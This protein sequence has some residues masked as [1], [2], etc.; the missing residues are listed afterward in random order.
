MVPKKSNGTKKK[1]TNHATRNFVFA[2]Y[3]ISYLTPWFV[4]DWPPSNQQQKNQGRNY[5]LKT[6]LILFQNKIPLSLSSSLLSLCFT[7]NIKQNKKEEEEVNNNNKKSLIK[8]NFPISFLFSPLHPPPP[9]LS[10]HQH[11]HHSLFFLSLSLPPFFLFVNY[12]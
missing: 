2:L 5:N 8:I 9:P 10:P 7:V 4:L 6:F 3:L 12:K 1:A 11:H